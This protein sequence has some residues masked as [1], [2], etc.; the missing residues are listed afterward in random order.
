MLA[1][2]CPTDAHP[3]A[4]SRTVS[5]SETERG[6]SVPARVTRYFYFKQILDAMCGLIL[7]VLLAP[8]VA[9]AA[10]LI[11]LTS[12]GP[13]FYRQVRLG[14]FGRPFRIWKLRTM[15][16]Q[17]EAGSGIRWSTPG[18]SRVTPIGRVLRRLHIDEIPQLINVLRGEMSLVG[19]RPERPEF[20]PA[21]SAAIPNYSHRLLVKPGVTGLAQVYLPPDEDIDGVI[22]KQRLDLYYIRQIGLGLDLRLLV[23]TALQAVGVPHVAVRSLLRLPRLATIG[24]PPVA[25]SP[26]STR[27]A[28]PSPT[29]LPEPVS[30]SVS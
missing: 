2:L 12:S 18:D 1:N 22:R 4:W 30:R 8:A 21:L 17:C 15:Q 24:V 29:V 14:R 23:A 3:K 26:G 28:I 11:R 7:V 6:G 27:P 13:A 25:V 20:F 5:R 9:V 19:P 16:H 10:I